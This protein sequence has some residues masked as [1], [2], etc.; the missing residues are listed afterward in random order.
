MINMN[1]SEEI[2]EVLNTVF[3]ENDGIAITRKEGTPIYTAVMVTFKKFDFVDYAKIQGE[4]M[5]RR[6]PTIPNGWK[7]ELR[8]DYLKLTLTFADLSGGW[9]MEE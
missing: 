9:D 7:V 5:K 3:P 1:Y 8:K 2:K 4:T 6:M